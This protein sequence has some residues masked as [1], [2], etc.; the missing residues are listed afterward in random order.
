MILRQVRGAA[1]LLIVM[2]ALFGALYPLA[3]WAVGQLAFAAAANGSL[4]GSAASW[5]ARV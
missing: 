5:A 1:L 3:I 4:I 2:T